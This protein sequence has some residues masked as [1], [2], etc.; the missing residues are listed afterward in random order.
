M[1]EDLAYQTLK[2]DK[3]LK[4]QHGG[5][6]ESQSSETILKVQRRTKYLETFGHVEMFGLLIK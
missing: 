1:I 6:R 3:A 5:T 4:R 2:H